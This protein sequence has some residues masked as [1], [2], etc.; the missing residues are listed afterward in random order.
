[1]GV[2][3]PATV[4]VAGPAA[5]RV[6]GPTMEKI[7]GSAVVSVAG[8][9]TVRVAGPAAARVAGPTAAR[10]AGPASMR[11]V[12][13][14]LVRVAG[15]TVRVF[16]PAAVKSG[17]FTGGG[18]IGGV[19]G[20]PAVST[21]GG[22][23]GSIGGGPAGSIAGGP[24]GSTFG[25]SAGSIGGVST[26]S[27]AGG[28]MGGTGGGSTGSTAD[29]SGVVPPGHSASGARLCCPTN[30][31]RAVRVVYVGREGAE[32]E[33]VL[34]AVQDAC[35][36]TDSLLEHATFGSL[37]FGEAAVLDS[38]YYADVALVEVG[39]CY[40]QPSLFYHVGVRESFNSRSTALLYGGTDPDTASSLQ[41]S[42]G[43]VYTFLTYC[44]APCGQAILC[45]WQSGL[46]RQ[47]VASSAIETPVGQP[48]GPL[49]VERLVEMLQHIQ[50]TSSARC[51]ATVLA[52]IRRARRD[53]QGKLLA[54]ELVRIR[55]RLDTTELLSPDIVVNLLLSYRDVQDY[56]AMVK[57]VE[58]LEML[59][60]CDLS[61]QNNIKFHY[62][63][64]LNRRGELG[65]RDKALSVMLAV[66]S[67]CN[68][69]PSDMYCLC[70]RIYKDNFLKS[71]YQDIE[72]RD[73]AI[74]WYRKGFELE[75]SLYA[76][77]HLSSLLVARGET[78]NSA[79]ELSRIGIK[80][81]S[82]LG[83]QGGLER[84]RSYWDVGLFI[85]VSLLAGDY[86][87]V[88]NAAEK[89]YHLHPP[90]W[91]MHSVVENGQLILYYMKKDQGIS[92]GHSSARPA[93]LDFWID[94]MAETSR[95]MEPITA[96][97]FPVLI[98]EPAGEYL[99]GYVAV[100]SETEERSV[101]LWLIAPTDTMKVTEW[102]IE[103]SEIRGVSISK[104][105][106]RCCFLYVLQNSND[107]Q[108]FLPS[109]GHAIR[110][111][112]MVKSFMEEQGLNMDLE[113]E[114]H[115]DLEWDY[116]YN[117]NGE[118]I[119]LGR[120]TFGVVYAGRD[121]HSHVRIAIKE[122]PEKDDRYSQPL[123]EEIALH[124][125][126]QHRN[127]VR[128]LGSLSHDGFF[129]I[130]MEQ[131][132]GG[133]L[134]SLLREK[135][136]PL[137]NN[138]ST[139]AF[140]TRQILQGIR[141]LHNNQIVHRDI[142]GDNV[143]INTYSGVLKISDFGTS[144]RLAGVNPS[145]ETFTGTLQYM[146]PEIIDRGQRG[147][148]KPADIWSLGCTVIEMASGRP[149][150][151]ELGE[152][153]VA[154]FKVGMFKIHPEIPETLSPE[155]RSF[156]LLCFE[157]EPERRAHAVELLQQPFLRGAGWGAR[158]RGQ[159][160]GPDYGRSVSVPIHIDTS[161]TGSEHGSSSSESDTPVLRRPRTA[162]PIIAQP[163]IFL[164]LPE[165]AWQSEEHSAPP[166]PDEAE[167]SLFLLRKD[168]ERRATLHRILA[169]EEQHLAGHL[170]QYLSKNG[171]PAPIS[172][173][174]LLDLLSGLREF[175][176]QP[177]TTCLATSMYAFR[178]QLQHQ[179]DIMTHMHTLLKNFQDVVSKV[180]RDHNIKPHWVFAL[181]NLVHTAVQTAASTLIPDLEQ[182]ASS[183]QVEEAN[184]NHGDEGH[185]T[186][187]V[188]TLSSAGSVQH[189]QINMLK[190]KLEQLQIQN[191]RLLERL[192]EK[193]KEYH[194]LLQRSIEHR[195]D[196][197]RLLNLHSQQL[198]ITKLFERLSE[199]QTECNSNPEL[200]IWL[201][202]HGADVHS[203]EKIL[204]EEYTLHDFLFL[205]TRT[206]LEALRLRG[207]TLCKLWKAILEHRTSLE[208]S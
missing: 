103:A 135:W 115:Q 77:V 86:A 23:A 125:H 44:V 37:D 114:N 35:E 98:Q 173:K 169:S 195:T 99:P 19:A 186:S 51:K 164:G 182:E 54:K 30:G 148:G 11:V 50:V 124:R 133:S 165:E 81:N 82:L 91:Y 60:T 92:S 14:A 204:A 208:D 113:L 190:E 161:S 59:P 101:L 207:G 119:V 168:S 197:I 180:L 106:E 10:V 20:G 127:I 129:K 32:G 104:H 184:G 196:D 194:E 63:F 34:R 157:P 150:F 13:P 96:L 147:Y 100:N 170:H 139:M 65:D 109:E 78:F 118:R 89:L 174:Q 41:A 97:R 38:F 144:K 27:T 43:S 123:H 40:R 70:G 94:F 153:H 18:P 152:P 112:S 121:L 111:H 130:L 193:E 116:E 84:I 159:K 15:P 163:K 171:E 189:T 192:I 47:P 6:A 29:G 5:V 85:G 149:P 1:M 33:A 93:P 68:Q 201:K 128:Y 179:P 90:S 45:E 126:L 162:Q 79:S 72:S 187:G 28:S 142:K 102:T 58:T 3:G 49:L 181:D 158:R 138:E 16:G 46:R 140:Y 151:H 136:G 145:T 71:N 160:T 57:L 167:P 69:P 202:E 183:F 200:E 199:T 134:S 178:L 39:D 52:E 137:Q 17:G 172:E 120:G 110:F 9:A 48:N 146:A 108:I 61:D 205:V 31:S 25:G 154:M 12:R 83:R 75:P 62:A 22:P 203:M 188:S 105:D 8:P 74:H 87:K 66:L 7:T 76:G 143:L 107:F 176:R 141:Y 88:V 53:L 131:V 156:M 2:A 26:G 132:P 36:T 95:G 67:G 198:D 191:G 155:A 56:D 166:S 21:F 42:C 175:I 73:K 64:A 117:D 80:L 24:A 185:V 4:R 206:D 122:I 177:D 55:Q